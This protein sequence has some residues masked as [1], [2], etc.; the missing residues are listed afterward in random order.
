MRVLRF[1]DQHTVD[2]PTQGV[3]LPVE[4]VDMEG[5]GQ[6][7][8]TDPDAAIFDMLG[9]LRRGPQVGIHVVRAV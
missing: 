2:I 5:I 9:A 7:P 6:A 1:P 4:A 8:W 3:G